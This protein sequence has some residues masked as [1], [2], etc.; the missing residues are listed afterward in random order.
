MLSSGVPSGFAQRFRITKTMNILDVKD[1]ATRLIDNAYRQSKDYLTDSSKT[2][3]LPIGALWDKASPHLDK[4]LAVYDKRD[5]TSIPDSTWNPFGESKESCQKELD[6]ILDALLLVLGTCGAAGYRKR[7]RSLQADITTSNHRVGECGEL[8]ISA[9]SEASLNAVEGLWIRSRESLQDQIA[10]EN[11]RIAER[12]QQ[13][14]TLK[15]AFRNH[16]KEIGIDFLPETADSFLLPVEDN[17]VSMAA[18]ISNIGRLTEQLQRLVEEC[19][20]APSHTKK[21]YGIYVLLV[22][23]IDRIEQHFVL[24]VDNNFF[25]RIESFKSEANRYIADA[26]AQRSFGAH[27]EL[28]S[29]NIVANERTIYACRL[30]ADTL[31]SQKLSIIDANKKTKLLLAAAVNSYR[32]VQLSFDVADLIG[33]CQTAFRSLSDLRLPQLRTFQNVHL[34]EELERLADRIVD[35]E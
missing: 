17:I 27:E 34:N 22:L 9:P 28:L 33:Q 8:M 2:E 14:E 10:D 6:A 7:I 21:Y 25:P 1:Q 18:V 5:S 15:V 19:K 3:E 35:K 23:A 30:L 20:E 26:K 32:T 11:D 16:L 13:I 24:E 12:K 31:R 29:A 4:A